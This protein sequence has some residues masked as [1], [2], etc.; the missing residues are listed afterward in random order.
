[1]SANYCAQ[2]ANLTPEEEQ[3]HKKVAGEVEKFYNA[4]PPDSKYRAAADTLPWNLFPNVEDLD[5]KIATPSTEAQ[6]RVMLF[7]MFKTWTSS[8]SKMKSWNLSDQVMRMS[9]ICLVIRMLSVDNYRR[10][11]ILQKFVNT[12]VAD[13]NLPLTIGRLKRILPNEPDVCTDFHFKQYRV[14]MQPLRPGHH[15]TYNKDYEFLPLLGRGSLG[16]GGFGIVE[17]VE[18][19]FSNKVY[20]RKCIKSVRGDVIRALRNE[21]DNL[22]KLDQHDHIIELVST[23]TRGAELGLLLQPVADCN[24]REFL[25]RLSDRHG[26]EWLLNRMYGCLS[27]ALAFLH[28]NGIRHKDVKPENIL[29]CFNKGYNVL[30]SDFGLSRDFGVEGASAS[31]G[32]PDSWTY[33]YVA[34]EV[35]AYNPRGRKADVFSLGCVFLEIATLQASVSFDALEQHFDPE[36]R[37]FQGNLGKIPD[38]VSKLRQNLDA[39]S[40]DL[41]SLEWCEL[42]LKETEDE[43]IS[44]EDL[45]RKIL[46]QT[47][48]IENQD[49][50]FCQ[51][52]REEPLK[53]SRKDSIP[54][55]SGTYLQLPGGQRSGSGGGT[56]KF[57]SI[58][59]LSVVQASQNG[60]PKI[61]VCHAP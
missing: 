48:E 20:A 21:I 19:I 2:L 43:R 5:G 29:V 30:L 13:K 53:P 17:K 59:D 40:A 10:P 36:D 56:V 44:M 41:L 7:T 42:M 8:T 58:A 28:V 33:R 6:I 12:T 24:L 39:N 51:A 34:P 14:A 31:T 27:V 32:K 35:Y 18:D 54:R 47:R 16:Q 25:T 22:R 38:W 55:T 52:C 9:R 3:E 46:G 60:T 11:E 50:Y 15:V 49:R 37:S 57:T 61:Q 45:V 23:Y 4:L 1:M 26:R